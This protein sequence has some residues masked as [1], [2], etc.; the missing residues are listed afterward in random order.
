MKTYM[1][2]YFGAAFLALFLVPMVL[3]LARHYNLVD[4]PGPRKVHKTPIPRIGGIAL[5]LSTFALV[6]PV[7]FLDNTVGRYF[8]E[9][10]AQFVALLA[11]AGFIFLV[12]LFDDLH[13]VRGYIKLAC[14]IAASLAICA[15]GATMS[16]VSVGGAYAFKTGWAAW[17]LS[18]L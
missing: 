4:A 8:R 16:S 10:Q 13:P 14:L 9:S 18:V 7:F 6:L 12:G 11:G 15:S 5:I 17:P 3:R 1:T 2:V